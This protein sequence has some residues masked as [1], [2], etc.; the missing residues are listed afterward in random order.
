[1]NLS[2][3]LLQRKDNELTSSTTTN[4]ENLFFDVRFVPVKAKENSN[5]DSI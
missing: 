2:V 1:M 5:D 4:A 3:L